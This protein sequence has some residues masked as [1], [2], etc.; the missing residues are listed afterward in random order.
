MANLAFIQHAE[1]NFEDSLSNY[2]Q[3]INIR[4]KSLPAFHPD[5]AVGYS[6]LAAV[7]VSMNNPSASIDCLHNALSISEKSLPDNHE[8]LAIIH[9]NLAIAFEDCEKY[10]EAS[11]HIEWA[12]DIAQQ[13]QWFDKGKLEN[14]TKLAKDYQQSVL[15]HS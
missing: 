1:K 8:S 15:T 10:D 9:Y 5:L 7:Y 12:I 6:N 11:K 3:V 4:L 13:C 2:Q 14:W